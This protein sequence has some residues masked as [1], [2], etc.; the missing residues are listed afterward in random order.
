MGAKEQSGRT[1]PSIFWARGTQG[2]NG[3]GIT[4]KN[5][6]VSKCKDKILDITDNFKLPFLS[7]GA[8]FLDSLATSVVFMVE[9]YMAT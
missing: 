8:E 7:C 5:P 1:W 3:K 6:F 4:L 2:K 9:Y